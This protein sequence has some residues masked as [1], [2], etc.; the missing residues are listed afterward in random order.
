MNILVATNMYPN[1]Y[2][3]YSGIFIQEH[4]DYLDKKYGIKCS[5]ITGNGSNNNPLVV[6]KKYC[7]FFIRILWASITQK[8]DLLHVHFAYPTGLLSLP[9]KWLRRK[10]MLL[11]VHGSDINSVSKHNIIKYSITK[12][13]LQQS[14]HIIAVSS[15]LKK[16][17]LLSYG[18]KG[19]KIS[20]I[21]MGMNSQIFYPSTS[22]HQLS[23]SDLHLLFVGRLT[24]VKG[25]NVL[26]NALELVQKKTEKTIKCSVVG[27]GE[28]LRE[29]KELVSSL[30]LDN[31][32][33]FLGIKSQSE[34]ADIMRKV[35][36]VVVPS[37]EEGFGL[38]AIE[39]FACGKPV[40]ASN[41]GGLKSLVKH[42]K[43]GFLFTPGDE[44]SLSEIILQFLN[45]KIRVYE[46]DC[47]N[48]STQ[49]D[50]NF[51]VDEVQNLYRRLIYG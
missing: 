3:P 50:M 46:I 6:L 45:N 37:Y 25:L 42:E 51:K 39:A 7:L 34:I 38:V 33:E 11:T 31:S 2:K 48:S 19:D 26:I 28:K 47:T 20:V 1:P 16:K 24:P 43:N 36:S 44:N 32:V 14:D 35:D 13:V 23:N 18:L 5:V 27:D 17:I 49:Y 22:K 15:D 21:D 29:Y 12:F 41:T 10:K 4:V 8:Y 30:S 40:I 9:A